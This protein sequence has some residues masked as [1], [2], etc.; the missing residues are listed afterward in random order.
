MTGVRIVSEEQENQ[1]KVSDSIKK[2][3]L[4]QKIDMSNEIDTFNVVKSLITS[5]TKI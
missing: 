4:T 5:W 1:V 3:K 2:K